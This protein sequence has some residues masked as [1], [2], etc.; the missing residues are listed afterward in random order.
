MS[1]QCMISIFE[2]YKLQM[3]NFF[4]IFITRSWNVKFVMYEDHPILVE[5]VEA[6]YN[7]Q[8]M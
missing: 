2:T 6:H 3:N 8:K 4:M 1:F 5:G 7:G